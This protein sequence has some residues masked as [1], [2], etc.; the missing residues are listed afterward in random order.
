MSKLFSELSRPNYTILG[1]DID[2]ALLLL[3]LRRVALF[4]NGV[5]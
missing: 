4:C 2:L 5:I 3:D 1:H